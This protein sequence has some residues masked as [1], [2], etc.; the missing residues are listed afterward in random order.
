MCQIEA[1]GADCTVAILGVHQRNV[2]LSARKINRAAVLRM[3]LKGKINVI[4]F[5][6]RSHRLLARGRR[7]DLGIFVL[8]R[9]VAWG[10]AVRVFLR[11][12]AA[13]TDAE[14]SFFTFLEKYHS[15]RW[16]RNKQ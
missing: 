5:P 12:L 13:G 16:F 2:Q 9:I 10:G 7:W 15:L 11:G 1:M 14:S 3:R 8:F 4:I 6:D